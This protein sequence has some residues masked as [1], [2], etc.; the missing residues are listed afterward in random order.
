MLGIRIITTTPDA[1]VPWLSLAKAKAA[2]KIDAADLSRDAEITDRIAFLC[3]HLEAYCDRIIGKRAIV[4]VIPG[5]GEASYI[6]TTH[7]PIVGTP[8]VR[9]C[10]GAV[11][12]PTLYTVDHRA[13]GLW[14][15]AGT[16]AQTIT[17]EY[18]CGFDP[19]AA[20]FPAN[21]LAAAELFIRV[22]EDESKRDANVASESAVDIGSV[23][24][25]VS[26]DSTKQFESGQFGAGVP[27]SVGKI[28]NPYRRAFA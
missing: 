16:W 26:V 15:N 2:L 20:T 21:L 24:Y 3:A 7:H 22:I 13:G 23:T 17:V 1:T 27:P 11:I 4:E 28:I 5:W 14:I 25:A 19:A 18:E 10:N 12:G 9:D 6:V 8:V